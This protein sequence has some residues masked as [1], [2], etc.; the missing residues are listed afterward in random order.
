[1]CL[2]KV[3][4]DVDA[5]DHVQE[6]GLED[7]GFAWVVEHPRRVLQLLEIMQSLPNRVL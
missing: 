3:D 1:M 4:A 7:E 5:L 2:E 6:V